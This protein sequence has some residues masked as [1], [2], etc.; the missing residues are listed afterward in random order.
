MQ[1]PVGSKLIKSGVDFA[2]ITKTTSSHFTVLFMAGNDSYYEWHVLDSWLS[3]P[4]HSILVPFKKYYEAIN[5][6]S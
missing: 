6:K 2:V 1:Y 3:S 4:A 5:I